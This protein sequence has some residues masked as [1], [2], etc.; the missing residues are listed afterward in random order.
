MKSSQWSF[1]RMS[2]TPFPLEMLGSVATEPV[3]GSIP[4]LFSPGQLMDLR[5]QG[6]AYGP[7]GS[8]HATQYIVDIGDV[9]PWAAMRYTRA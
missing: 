2:A 7:E 5:P 8:E 1:E 3:E 6:S 9:S 4:V